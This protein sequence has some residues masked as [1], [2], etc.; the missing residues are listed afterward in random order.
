MGVAAVDIVGQVFGRLTVI[1][2]AGSY[3]E[4][5]GVAAL[6]L[7]N[8]LCGHEVIV[9]GRSLRRGRTKSCGCDKH[10]QSGNHYQ[11]RKASPIY[12][13][14]QNMKRRCYDPKSDRYSSYGGNGITVCDRW[15][16]SFENFLAD[17]GE[18]PVGTSLGRLSDVGNYVPGN[19]AWQT[20]AEQIA[21]RRPD[22]ARAWS[23]R[24]VTE[25]QIAA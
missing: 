21:N 7:C 15:K 6:W 14:W 18:R 8:C 13:A 23:K 17:L 12:I 25:Q 10:G 5:S 2:R 4:S 1:E 9:Q 22:R 20:L 16:D 3:K 11:G 19:V 24:K